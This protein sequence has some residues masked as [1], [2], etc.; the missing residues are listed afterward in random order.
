MHWLKAV[1]VL[2][3]T[4]AR[5]LGIIVLILSWLLVRAA[6]RAMRHGGTNIRPD[7]PTPSVVTDG[8][9]GFSC[10]P[11]ISRALAC[12]SGSLYSAT[13]SGRWSRY[14]P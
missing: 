9:L 4:P 13:P 6:E 3:A 8:P 10:N 7:H 1:H 2:P 12:I 11:R 14:R 5:V